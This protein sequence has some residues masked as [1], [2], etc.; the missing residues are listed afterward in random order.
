MCKDAVENFVI[1]F[2]FLWA[3]MDS[4]FAV[5]SCVELSKFEINSL[6]RIFLGI[7]GSLHYDI[8]NIAAFNHVLLTD[9]FLRYLLSSANLKSL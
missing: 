7:H 8:N 1:F 9:H 5:G 4:L 3:P 6:I 2:D